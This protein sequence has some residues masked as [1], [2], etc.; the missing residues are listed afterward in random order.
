M[1]TI[2]LTFFRTAMHDMTTS[3]DEIKLRNWT[4]LN[5]KKSSYANPSFGIGKKVMPTDIIF[6]FLLIT[7]CGL[8]S[9][10]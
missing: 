6:L 9:G 3:F 7:K 8:L 5:E 1:T 4:K 2:V 10:S